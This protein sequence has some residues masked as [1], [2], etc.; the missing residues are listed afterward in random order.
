MLITTNAAE[1]ARQWD[2]EKIVRK[3]NNASGYQRANCGGRAHNDYCCGE[4]GTWLK[5]IQ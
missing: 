4:Q 5:Y 3:R 2:S 1:V